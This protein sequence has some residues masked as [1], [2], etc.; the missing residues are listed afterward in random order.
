[1]TKVIEFKHFTPYLYFIF[2]TKQ[3]NYENN[4]FKRQKL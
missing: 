4:S 1:M 2:K 3:K